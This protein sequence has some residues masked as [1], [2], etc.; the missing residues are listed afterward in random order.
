MVPWNKKDEDGNTVA[1]FAV[2]NNNLE[3]VKMLST[4]ND[5]DWTIQND[6]GVTPLIHAVQNDN[7]ECVRILSKIRS[8][9]S[10]K[11]VATSFIIALERNLPA[12]IQIIFSMP[13]L[14][15]N[16]RIINKLRQNHQKIH[17]RAVDECKKYVSKMIYSDVNKEGNNISLLIFALQN[18]VND[19]FVKLLVSGATTQDILDLVIYSSHQK[20]VVDE[21][22]EAIMTVEGDHKDE[23]KRGKKFESFKKF[24]SRKFQFFWEKLTLRLTVKRK[25]KRQKNQAR[26]IQ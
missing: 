21:E 1:M 17:E 22:V 19:C 23:K 26:K 4:V 8:K 3:Y 7:V 10:T 9:F 2:T 25:R 24:V 20:A 15:I 5:I 6:E 14:V 16:E 18:N 12:M 13:D 11:S